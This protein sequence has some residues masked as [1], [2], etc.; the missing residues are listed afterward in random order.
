LKK[1]KNKETVMGSFPQGGT[2][3]LI[4]VTP[5]VILDRRMV[6]KRNRVAVD[7]LIQWANHVAEDA[8]WEPYEEIQKRF[9]DFAI[10]P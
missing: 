2:D 10:D 6:K 4:V 1:C 7:L 3:G 9:P 8:T 5:I